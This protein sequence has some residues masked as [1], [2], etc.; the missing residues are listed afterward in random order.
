[1]SSVAATVRF[2]ELAL[3]D[4]RLNQIVWTLGFVTYGQREDEHGDEHHAV[5]LQLVA[6]QRCQTIGGHELRKIGDVERLND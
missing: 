4:R 6:S 5:E 2:W 3:F 1:M